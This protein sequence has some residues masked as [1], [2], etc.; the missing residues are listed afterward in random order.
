MQLLGFTVDSHLHHDM[1]FIALNY[2][3]GT[4]LTRYLGFNYGDAE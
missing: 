1:A 2:G 4:M 3:P